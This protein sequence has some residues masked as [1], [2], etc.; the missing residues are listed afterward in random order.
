MTTAH[1]QKA[2]RL[3][4]PELTHTVL[5]TRTQLLSFVLCPCVPSWPQCSPLYSE[6]AQKEGHL[7]LV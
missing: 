3:Q 2:G 7:S 1:A 5:R 6:G 4:L